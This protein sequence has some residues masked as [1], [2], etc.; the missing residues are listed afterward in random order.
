MHKLY[1]R[2]ILL[3][4]IL[5]L[6]AAGPSQAQIFRRNAVKKAERGMFRKSHSSNRDAKVKK[7]R[8]VTKARK[9]QEA[10]Q[11]KLKKDYKKSV[12]ETRK[13]SYNI[14]TPD[15]KAR[16]D[17]NRKDTKAREKAKRKNEKKKNRKAGRKY[18]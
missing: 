8:A 11:K 7:P 2:R 6:L 12:I 16:M 14:Q 17:Q 9:K 4:L 15:V 3:L 18:K 13:H 1:Q 10:H 5:L